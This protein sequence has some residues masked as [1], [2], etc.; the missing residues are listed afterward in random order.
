MSLPKAVVYHCLNKVSST[1]FNLC[2]WGLLCDYWPFGCSFF[3]YFVCLYRLACGLGCALFYDCIL[4]CFSGVVLVISAM[5]LYLS[6][7][8]LV[9]FVHMLVLIV[10]CF[11][12]AILENCLC[13]FAQDSFQLVFYVCSCPDLFVS[14]VYCWCSIL[15]ELFAY[16]LFTWYARSV[17]CTPFWGP[18]FCLVLICHQVGMPR[19]FSLCHL[20]FQLRDED[21]NA[22][23]I[24]RRDGKVLILRVLF[25]TLYALL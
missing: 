21:V 20:C 14:S 9:L 3:S 13:C 4:S 24:V 19:S 18:F 5:I 2:M 1:C 10:C 16:I 17:C 11:D 12:V 7:C 23:T 15:V 22:N 8:N 25:L 6:W